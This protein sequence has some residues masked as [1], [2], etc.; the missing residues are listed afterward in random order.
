M[1]SAINFHTS[2]PLFFQLNCFKFSESPSCFDYSEETLNLDESSLFL[3]ESAHQCY[4]TCE[5]AY[6]EHLTCIIS[7]YFCYHLLLQLLHNKLFT[8]G[9][10]LYTF[11]WVLVIAFFFVLF[12]AFE[13]RYVVILTLLLFDAKPAIIDWF[14]LDCHLN[15][16]NEN[17]IFLT[18][19]IIILD[20]IIFFS[21]L[22]TLKE[23]LSILLLPE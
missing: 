2:S 16:C 20:F 3:F 22:L 4:L 13:V 5:L 21:F 14:C 19:L 7:H 10:R 9:L 6:L 1:M 23:W 17:C 12:D 11:A 18:I 8:L 15:L